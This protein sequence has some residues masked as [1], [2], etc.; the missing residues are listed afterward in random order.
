MRSYQIH[1]ILKKPV[2]LEIGKLGK[3][4]FPA[5]KYV[6][7]ESAK[8]N[9]EARISRHLS[10]SKKLRWHI[11]YLMATSR[12][13]FLIGVGDTWRD[14]AAIG[15]RNTCDS[16]IRTNPEIFENASVFLT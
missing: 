6:Y 2:V 4:G 11:D 9:M 15:G 1:F 3:F 12:V 16:I 13:G 7:T 8:K 14:T 5:G 10:K